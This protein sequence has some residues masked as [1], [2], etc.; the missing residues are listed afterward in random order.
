VTLEAVFRADYGRLCRRA[1]ALLGGDYDAAEQVVQ[2]VFEAASRR[3]HRIEEPERYVH[4]AVINRACS[5]A[6][7][8]RIE[9]R[10]NALF[11]ARAAVA[12]PPDVDRWVDA[13]RVDA[14]LQRLPRRQRAVAVLYYLED[15]SVE[16]VAICWAAAKGAVKN[17][18]SAAR[19]SLKNLL[20]DQESH[21]AH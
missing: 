17:R 21:D 7:R 11:T 10:A 3:W 19:R 14:A 1:A 20:L 18:L 15:R 16:D 5:L 6:S 2:D 4:R 9:A 13:E 8:R 12:A